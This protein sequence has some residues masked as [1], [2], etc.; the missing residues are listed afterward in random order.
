MKNKNLLILALSFLLTL[1]SVAFVNSTFVSADGVYT[2]SAESYDQETGGLSYRKISYSTSPNGAYVSYPCAYEGKYTDDTCVSIKYKNNGV[3][4]I[5]VYMEYGPGINAGG[6]DYSAGEEIICMD[7]LDSSSWNVSYSKS[8]DGYDVATI[9]FGNYT[10]NYYDMILTGFR[11]RFDEG[12]SVNS[13]R[14]FEVYG[15]T[16]HDESAVPSFASDPKSCRIGKVSVSGAEFKQNSG[17]VN[18]EAVLT[19]PILDFS[20][21][22][23]KIKVGFTVNGGA[24]VVIKLDGQSVSTAQYG[25]GAHVETLDFVKDNYDSLE[26]VVTANGTLFTL[27]QL[28]LVSDPYVDEFTGSKYTISKQ[29]DG[30]TVVS[31]TYKT[32]W[33]SIKAPIRRYTSD[34]DGLVIEFSIDTPIVLGI[35]IDGEYIRSHYTYKDPLTVGDHVLTFSLAEL[36]LTDS[37]S[38]EFWLDPAI[39]G[40]AGVEGTK[41]IV[42]KSIRFTASSELPKA[43]I[44]GLASEFN[45]TYDGK[46]K[47][48]SGATTNSG[49]ALVYEYKLA[50]AKESAYDTDLPVDAGEYDVRVTSPNNADF[51]TTYAYAKLYIAKAD[52]PTHT[53]A[54]VSID[55]ATSTLSYDAS[56]YAVSRSAEFTSIATSGS[57]VAFGDVLYVKYIE[58]NN[59]KES[60]AISFTLNKREGSVTVTIN[61]VRETTTQNIEADTEYS[62]DGLN[63]TAGSGKKVTLEPGNIYLFRKKA[64]SNSFAGEI[65]YLAIDYRPEAP[66]TPVLESTTSNSITF[67]TIAGAEYKLEDTVWQSDPTFTG[68]KAGSEVTVYIRIKGTSDSYASETVSAT[69]IVGQMGAPDSS[70]SSSEVISSTTSSD[71]GGGSNGCVAGIVAGGAVA[72]IAVA[73]GV[74]LVMKKRRAE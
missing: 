48:A 60:E 23:K 11:L 55:Y 74:V 53:A 22:Y 56:L 28:I 45:F 50:S 39:T 37:S 49:E 41:T 10:S 30:S 71:Q 44:S 69:F 62:K 40:Y 6:S 9:I 67:A 14:S 31:Y 38:I 5:P 63:W 61:Y 58:S 59:Y 13:E 36:S 20:N 70:E 47:K 43:T 18:G 2:I 64:T 73:V 66:A 72:A 8:V 19:A 7:M 29:S 1:S 35:M 17:V 54:C 24:T 68:L 57:G 15:L 32:G 4:S 42:F 21:E 52:A 26:I 65:T 3:T 16:V 27:N 51:A 12:K 46:G 25:V 34:Y 33:N